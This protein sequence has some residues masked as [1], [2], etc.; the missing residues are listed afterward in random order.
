[1]CTKKLISI[2][3]KVKN[4]TAW[5]VTLIQTPSKVDGKLRISQVVWSGGSG[6]EL[7]TEFGLSLRLPA[8]KDGDK[9][10]FPLSQKSESGQWTRFLSDSISDSIDDESRSAPYILFRAN[11]TMTPSV[12]RAAT[13]RASSSPSSLPSDVTKAP[14]NHSNHT[15]QAVSDLSAQ[16][17]PVKAEEL[18]N[19]DQA[20]RKS[21]AD[22]KLPMVLSV[23]IALLTVNIW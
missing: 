18:S 5:A 7:S 11:V 20:T 4:T 22:G 14:E 19:S 9:L 1:M 2:C 12:R 3:F 21:A 16:I 10:F 13:V 23:A 17:F 6:N 8:L 15:T